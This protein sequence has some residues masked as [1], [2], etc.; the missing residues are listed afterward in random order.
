MRQQ[1]NK[2]KWRGE[3]E[4]KQ[5]IDS[6][7]ENQTENI[8]ERSRRS[9]GRRRSERS[10]SQRSQK[11]RRGQ[12]RAGGDMRRRSQGRRRSWVRGS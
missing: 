7:K 1:I 11:R 3:E 8:M 6:T 10:R 2:E 12:R 5:G 4:R 9:Q